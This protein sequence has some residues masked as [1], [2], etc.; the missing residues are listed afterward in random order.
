VL[1]ARCAGQIFLATVLPVL[2]SIHD[3]LSNR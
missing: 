2:P 1:E 3:H